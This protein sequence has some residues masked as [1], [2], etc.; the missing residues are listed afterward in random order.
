[1]NTRQ[2]RA[3]RGFRRR[4]TGLRRSTTGG[5]TWRVRRSGGRRCCCARSTVAGST[6]SLTGLLP[7][8]RRRC[9]EK[10]DAMAAA[11]V[12]YRSEIKCGVGE[13]KWGCCMAPYTAERGRKGA[14]GSSAAGGCSPWREGAGESGAG[15]WNS[16]AP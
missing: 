2:R 9:A 1:M 5:L 4:H 3:H 6:T 14:M 11:A 12:C 8:E 13:G 15:C 7:L 10:M 16:W